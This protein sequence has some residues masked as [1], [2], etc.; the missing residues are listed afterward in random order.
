M[1]ADCH[2]SSYFVKFSKREKYRLKKADMLK[3]LLL[4]YA[5]LLKS[6]LEK[7]LASS[8]TSTTRLFSSFEHPL[9]DPLTG[10]E[11]KDLNDR[12]QGKRV[13]FYF[14]AGWCPMCTSFE[15]AMNSFLQSASDTGKPIELIYVSSDKNEET[16]MKRAAYLDMLTVPFGQVTA[17]LKIK[18]NI[19]AGSESFQFG[20]GR[21]SGVPALV[22]LDKDGNELSFLAAESQGPK[23]LE[24]WPLDDENGIW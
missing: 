19:W 20:F 7:P 12:L 14:A 24:T 15:P 2:Q 6:S 5:L 22:V 16:S 17:D 9:I 8:M 11:T 3:P 1:H 18:Y 10:E 23:A 13:A 21:R 4:P